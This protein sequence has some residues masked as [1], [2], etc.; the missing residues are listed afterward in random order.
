VCPIASRD[1]AVMP[2]FNMDLEMMYKMDGKLGRLQ[3][4]ET[5]ESRINHHPNTKLLVWFNNDHNHERKLRDRRP[6]GVPEVG[7]TKVYYA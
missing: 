5:T 3:V 6:C 1:V 7:M 4:V 2:K